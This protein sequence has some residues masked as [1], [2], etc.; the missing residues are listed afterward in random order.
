MLQGLLDGLCKPDICH[1]LMSAQNQR[2]AKV[3]LAMQHIIQTSHGAAVLCAARLGL[4]A[5]SNMRKENL[6]SLIQMIE[7]RSSLF[8]SPELEILFRE[9]NFQR[10]SADPSRQIP[11]EPQLL[12]STTHVTAEKSRDGIRAQ[13]TPGLGGP[14]PEISTETQGSSDTIF[15]LCVGTA[16][17]EDVSK[18]DMIG[19]RLNLLDIETLH[20]DVAAILE[21]KLLKQ[22][23][24]SSG[25]A[26]IKKDLDYTVIHQAILTMLFARARDR[27]EAEFKSWKWLVSNVLGNTLL[28]YIME[29]KASSVLIL[30]ANSHGDWETLS[31]DDLYSHLQ[32]LSAAHG[33]LS[34]CPSETENRSAACKIADIRILDMIARD[35]DWKYSYRP[36]TCFGMGKCTLPSTLIKRMAT[37]RGYSCGGADVKIVESTMRDNLECIET[38]QSNSEPFE[39]V[40]DI[41]QPRFFHQEYIESLQKLGEYRVFISRR[42]VIE[43]AFTT[44]NHDMEP[45]HFAAEKATPNHFK[46]FSDDPKKRKQK[47][48]ELKDFALYQN[49]RLL[50]HPDNMEKF[51][52]VHVGIRLDIG[53]SELNGN[54]RFFVSEPTR[55]PMADQLANLILDRPHVAIARVW[56]E[57]MIEQHRRRIRGEKQI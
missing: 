20:K 54:G 7:E 25:K 57:S 33:S 26:F 44:V 42:Q 30:L 56:G 17:D 28:S 23:K 47:L 51:G 48:E 2:Y 21:G 15:L 49:S 55:F 18:G 40:P 38:P 52:S 29:K 45:P 6:L 34:I 11:S 43:I 36:R 8:S 41:R 9:R 37:K 19:V 10:L 27:V 24:E 12:T 31:M 13:D 5:L 53:V 1:G 46:W 4:S 35:A 16:A 32:M 14:G 39:F 22:I 50:N 3:L